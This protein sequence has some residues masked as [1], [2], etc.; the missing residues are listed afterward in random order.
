[1]HGT[2]SNGYEN[3]DKSNF[4]HKMGSKVKKALKS[5]YIKNLEILI[6]LLDKKLFIKQ[7]NKIHF[8]IVMKDMVER[9]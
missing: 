2:K 3:R 8:F 7:F 6:L 9:F 5:T 4:A 1:M